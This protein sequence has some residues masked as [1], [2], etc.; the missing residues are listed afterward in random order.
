MRLY[1]FCNQYLSSIQNGIQSLHV[2]SEMFVKY[3]RDDNSLESMQQI[4]LQEWA[5]HH[6]TVVLLNAGYSEELHNLIDFLNSKENP[7][8]WGSFF[9]GIDALDGALTCVGIVLPE[10]IYEMSAL[11]RDG[12]ALMEL[13]RAAKDTGG[14]T[15][16]NVRF[17]IA[18]FDNWELDMI[19]RLNQYGLAR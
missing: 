5:T 8:P 7:Y 2:V 15:P 17:D 16:P 6:K 19:D 13:V 4:I 12:K 10:K 18:D 14:R 3:N 11:V 9:E 1:T